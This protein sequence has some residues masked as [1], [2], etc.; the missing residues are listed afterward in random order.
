MR[1]EIAE[2]RRAAMHGSCLSM[3]LLLLPCCWVM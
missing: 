1:Y 2:G 3:L